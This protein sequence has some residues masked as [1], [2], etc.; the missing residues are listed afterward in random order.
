MNLRIREE[1]ETLRQ[2][3]DRRKQ[4]KVD[5]KQLAKEKKK[6]EKRV[7]AE[8]LKVCVVS[9]DHTVI[10][11]KH[12]RSKRLINLS[13]QEWSKIRDDLECDDLKDLPSPIPVQCAIPNG[14]FGDFIMVL[15]FFLA[16]GEELQLKDAF[17]GGLTFELLERAVIE[18]EVSGP[19]SDILQVLLKSL[20]DFQ[21]TEAEE[22]K[23][24]HSTTTPLAETETSM[25]E[26]GLTYQVTEEN[27]FSSTLPY[28][29]CYCTTGNST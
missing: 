21:D 2:I 12:Y 16:F 11:R 3:A 19:L 15:E 13:F 14:I 18:N 8:T 5:E 24:A 26:G 22:V 25:P 1:R 28:I 9:R 17:P 7:L 29:S 10:Y 27:V 23:E 6:E 20:F 4:Q